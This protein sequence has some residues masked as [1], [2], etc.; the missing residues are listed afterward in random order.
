MDNSILLARFIGPYIIVI[1]VSLMLNQKT[2]RQIVE[3]FPKSPSLVYVTGLMT[4]VAGLAIVLN[5]NLWVADWRVI[6]TVFGWM[7]FIKGLWLVLFP[8]TLGKANKFFLKNFKTA[9]F[10]W[11]IMILVGISLTMKGYFLI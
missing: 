5:H 11:S 2:F 8:G 9:L 4:F 10:I 7:A 3:E 6:I 1:G